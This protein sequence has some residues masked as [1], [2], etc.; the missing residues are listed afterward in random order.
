MVGMSDQTP[1]R[2]VASP[3]SDRRN[4]RRALGILGLLVA[5]LL[6]GTVGVL[7]WVV[8]SAQEALNRSTNGQGGNVI[9]VL[10]PGAPQA[11]T[12]SPRVNI[13]VAGNT[14][15]D[16]GHPGGGLTD[17][18][19]VASIDRATNK[20]SLISIPRDLWVKFDGSQMKINA[21]SPRA[22]GG[23]AGLKALGGI[24]EQ[25][26]GLHIDKHVL[27]GVVAFKKVVDDVG[28]IDVVIDSTDPRG[29]G[30]PNIGLY[31]PSGPVHLDGETALKLASSRNDPV[32]GKESYGLAAGDYSR[33]AN[34]RL[35]ITGVI[36]KVKSTPTLANPLTLTR[37]FNDVS[38]NLTTDLTAKD[39]KWLL[40]V[41]NQVG[42]P[43]SLSIRGEPGHLLIKNYTGY[44]G[45]AAQAPIAGT[46]NYS[47]IR[48]YVAGKLA[49]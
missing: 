25:V 8:F 42:T 3:S 48:T 18:I 45:S 36:Q 35:I 41:A 14:A 28:G 17:T 39:I 21:V 2:A 46:F 1:R 6:A 40:G 22:G 12:D 37:M 32:P 19:I 29:I 49:A 11:P 5:V 15:D 44:G 7:G 26:T 24:V 16:P 30:D 47:A 27:L 43:Q 34:Q 23:E 4:S 31:L 20:L 33:Q 9:D 10:L 13:L 38:Q